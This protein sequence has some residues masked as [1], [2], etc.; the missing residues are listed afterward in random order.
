MSNDPELLKEFLV[1]SFENLDS[2]DQE[3][4]AL[5]SSPGD[6][7][8]LNCIFRRVHTIKGTCGFLELKKLESITHVG[9]NLLDSLRAGRLSMTQEIASALLSLIDAMRTILQSVEALDEEGDKDYSALVERLGSFLG[10][11]PVADSS[12]TPQPEAVETAKAQEAETSRTAEPADVCNHDL[13]AALAND[14]NFSDAFA[15]VESSAPAP[16]A[17]PEENSPAPASLA[18]KASEKTQAQAVS[19][20]ASPG[21]GVAESS[22]RVDVGLL[23]QLMNL[24]GELVLARNQ[25]LQFTK[26]QTDPTYLK[27]SQRLN[28]ITSELQ[29]RV[30]RTRMQPISNVWNKFPRVVRDVAKLCGKEVRLDMEGKDTELDKTI[31]EAIKDPLTHII[32]N[33]VDHG[34]EAPDVRSKTGKDREGRILL[35]AFHEGGHVIIEIIDD[36]GGLNTERIKKK[37]VEKGLIS[38]ERANEMSKT[39]IQRLIFAA[40]FST[41]EQVTNISGRGVGMDV[42][43][44]NIERIGGSV[45]ISSELGQGTTLRIKIPL[46]LAIVPALIVSSGGQIFAVPQV[47]LVEL[48][49]L[50]GEKIFTAVEEINGAC[51]HRLRG[52]LLP[53]VYLNEELK[54]RTSVGS[55]SQS[56]GDQVLNVVVVRAESRQFGIVVDEVHD[57]EEIVV[58]PLGKQFKSVLVFAGATIMGDGKV[59]LIVD[60]PGLARKARVMSSQEARALASGDDRTKSAAKPA[61]KLLIVSL[62]DGARGAIPLSLVNRLEEFEEEIMERAG[63]SRVVQ[64]RGG[65]LPLID[66]PGYFGRQAQS[67]PPGEKRHVVVYQSEE[68]TFGL[69]VEGIVDIVEEHV[70]MQFKSGKRGVLGS[71]VIQKKVTDL[72]DVGTILADSRP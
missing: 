14:P 64:Y 48:V 58:K 7:A 40:G 63:G 22:I 60:V 33:A 54:L 44:S 69:L 1:E 16:T 66:L 39:E 3:M 26:T 34:V 17:A 53:L 4:V 31:L 9:E 50:S 57:T 21:S 30:M 20:A 62:G 2:L 51:F 28:L 29:E 67:A 46:T 43:R 24:V 42:V 5:E 27:T 13:L 15:K 19:E 70:S 6:K 61:D 71:A 18:E 49:R 55:A 72:M 47:S 45:D 11:K 52:E 36:G 56:V 35:K 41:A 59:A 68:Q 32:R 25:V 10:A 12:S 65:I 37:A 23:D 8:I 38:A